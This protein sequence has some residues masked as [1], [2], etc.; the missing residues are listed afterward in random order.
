VSIFQSQGKNQ[1]S[2]ESNE[3][4]FKAENASLTFE[5][6]ECRNKNTITLNKHVNCDSCGRRLTRQ[7]YKKKTGL[8]KSALYAIVLAAVIISGNY[9]QDLYLKNLLRQ[10]NKLDI[11]KTYSLLDQCIKNPMEIYSNTDMNLK[12]D[13]CF[14][15]FGSGLVDDPE[16][17]AAG[18]YE[19]MQVNMKKYMPDCKNQKSK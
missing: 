14:C 9:M 10:K 13:I 18:G 12:R 3:K 15:A 4:K 19:F 17:A 1:T 5:C 7:E 16:N 11:K 6:P 2:I 8:L